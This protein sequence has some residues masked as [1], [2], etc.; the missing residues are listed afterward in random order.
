VVPA[1]A[2]TRVESD[3]AGVVLVV[4]GACT[5]VVFPGA[6]TAVAS[7]A[8]VVAAVVEGGAYTVL[9]AG[10]TVSPAGSSRT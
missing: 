10:N 2:G 6:I 8:D 9:G 3:A 1:G 5:T 4:E 7:G